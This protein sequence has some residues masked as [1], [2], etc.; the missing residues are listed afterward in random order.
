MTKITVTNQSELDAERA[1]KLVSELRP[2]DHILTDR[3]GG[4]WRD[5]VHEV[6]HVKPTGS[7]D[8]VVTVVA[9]GKILRVASATPVGLAGDAEIEARARSRIVDGLR[10][11]A[12][13][14]AVDGLPIDRRVTPSV[15]FVM[16]RRATVAAWAEAFGT[17]VSGGGVAGDIP[18]IGPRPGGFVFGGVEVCV[19]AMESMP[20]PAPVDDEADMVSDPRPDSQAL[21]AEAWMV[22]QRERE[23]GGAR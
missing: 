10:T 17:V 7:G 9:G 15:T 13:K 8:T 21:E 3:F 18:T 22:L 6:R 11:L 23:S 20:E 2:G 5:Q 19:Q 4:M 1:Y 14:I 12:D 16:D